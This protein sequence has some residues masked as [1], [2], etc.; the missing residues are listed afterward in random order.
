MDARLMWLPH[1]TEK[2][3]IAMAVEAT[4]PTASHVMLGTG[5]TTLSPQ[6]FA[7]LF[8]PLGPGTVFAPAY[9]YVVSVGGDED[10]ADISRSAIDLYV[11][12]LAANK[13]H[14]A[15]FDPQ[16]VFDHENEID[17]SIIEAELGQMMFGP[18]SSYIRPGVGI[19]HD[20]PMDWNIEF[21][22]KVIWK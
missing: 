8:N 7:V 3:A 18:T 4:F 2:G 1:L 19:G 6:I 10:R 21:G 12:W 11:V 16:I 15:I 22:F 13:K 5:K 9:Q 20:R 17:F 14:W